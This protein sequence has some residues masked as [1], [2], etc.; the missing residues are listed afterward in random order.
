M[1][2]AVPAA[3]WDNDRVGLGGS[4]T[5]ENM[6]NPLRKV[7]SIPI[8][9]AKFGYVCARPHALSPLPGPLRHIQAGG[10]RPYLS[11]ER[12]GEPGAEDGAV[13]TGVD[14]VSP[15]VRPLVF[16]QDLGGGQD[17]EIWTS[18]A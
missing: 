18:Y 13:G 1:G 8:A 16:V 3:T 11:V 12:V 15:D 7:R 6:I 17:L 2:G 10:R 5:R 4:G 14:D 9:P